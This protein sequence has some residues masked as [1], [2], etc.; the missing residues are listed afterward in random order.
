VVQLR[1]APLGGGRALGPVSLQRFGMAI[2]SIGASL[3][4]CG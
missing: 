4:R 2:V 1:G 3:T